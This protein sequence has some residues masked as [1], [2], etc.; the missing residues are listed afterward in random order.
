[1]LYNSYLPGNKHANRKHMEL[2]EIYELVSKEKLDE[3]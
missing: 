1:M 3:N 2:S